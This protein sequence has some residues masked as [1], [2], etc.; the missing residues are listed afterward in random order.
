MEIIE[1][2]PK[3]MNTKAA[4]SVL[5]TLIPKKLANKKAIVKIHHPSC[6]HC[7]AMEKEWNKMCEKGCKRGS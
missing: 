5:A 3:S 4:R 7:V 1:I 6:P 2:S